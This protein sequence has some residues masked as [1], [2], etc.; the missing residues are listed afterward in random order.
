MA[1]PITGTAP[2]AEAV[3]T[4]SGAASRRHLAWVRCRDAGGGRRNAHWSRTGWP[5]MKA[6]GTCPHAMPAV[7]PFACS[8]S[9]ACSKCESWIPSSNGRPSST[10]QPTS[11]GRWPRSPGAGRSRCCWTCR[12]RTPAGAS[13]PRWPA[14]KRPRRARCCGRARLDWTPCALPG[15]PPVWLPGRPAHR[16]AR[17][18]AAARAGAAGARGCMGHARGDLGR[19]HEARVDAAVRIR[20][21]PRVRPAPGGTYRGLTS[22]R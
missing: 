7:G 8:G 21:P 11:D 4:I 22:E 14:W 5:S 19:D 1:E 13:R 16:A 15:R 17:G 9:T 12:R 6:A 20:R 10:P 3:F 2:A 18:A